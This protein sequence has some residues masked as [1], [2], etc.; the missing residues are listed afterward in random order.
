MSAIYGGTTADLSDVFNNVIVVRVGSDIADLA[1]RVNQFLGA[2]TLSDLAC[3]DVVGS[4]DGQQF[5]C[6]IHVSDTVTVN[7]PIS[8]VTVANCT[9]YLSDTLT[10]DQLI[11]AHVDATHRCVFAK[12]AGAPQ[13]SK[14]VAAILVEYLPLQ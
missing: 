6:L 3:F 8:I 4:G 14:R 1:L 9:L 13:G 12:N 10:V 7:A 2:V 11:A 5:C